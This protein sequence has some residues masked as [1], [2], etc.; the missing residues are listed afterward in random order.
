MFSLDVE[1]TTFRRRWI[2]FTADRMA[3]PG[4]RF[5]TAKLILD[6]ALDDEY[7]FAAGVRIRLQIASC[8]NPGQT[9]DPFGRL[10]ITVK[11]QE[12]HTFHSTR[13]PFGVVG[14]DHDMWPALA[15]ILLQ[16]HK[17]RAPVL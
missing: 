7:L 15:R 8:W 13:L 5:V 9:C 3:E 2:V 10:G 16:L 14:I 4:S 12:L 1:Q 11:R 6:A 17:K